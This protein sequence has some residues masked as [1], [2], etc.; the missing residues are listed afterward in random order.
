[1]VG[2]RRYVDVNVFVY[3]LGGHPEFGEAARKWV[4]E[5]E[6]APPGRF[7][8]SAI[9]VYEALVIIAGLTGR[10]LRD[11]GF[12][13]GIIEAITGLASLVLEPLNSS[14]LTEALS[15][16]EKYELDYEDALHLAV[17]LRIGAT[18]VVSNDDDFDKG[19]LRRVF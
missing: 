14:D 12:A 10:D 5:V 16:M 8:T 18:E 13:S 15:L 17:A 3:W 1:M 7:A 4:K 6:S 19:P 11:A 9:T 2:E